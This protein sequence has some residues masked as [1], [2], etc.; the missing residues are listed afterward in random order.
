MSC[1]YHKIKWA[2]RI[3]EFGIR[4]RESITNDGTDFRCLNQKGPLSY[5]SFKFNGPGIRYE[6]AIGIL[7]GSIVWVSKMYR[8]A[9]HDI[10]IFRENL[11]GMLL[12]ADEKAVADKG[13]QGE[14]D[15]IDLPDEGSIEWQQQKN[16]ARARHETCNRRFKT[17]NVMG[18]RF[19]HNI[20]FHENCFHAVAVITQLQL[21]NGNPLFDIGH[22]HGNI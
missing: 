7:T 2:N 1:S 21:E 22:V 19:R 9:V 18:M 6:V 13:Y 8:A 3:N 20:D 17:W 11:M 4:L 15:T 16:R 5:Y 12:A 10:T 14:P